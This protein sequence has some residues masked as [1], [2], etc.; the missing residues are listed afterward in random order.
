MLADQLYDIFGEMDTALR[1]KLCDPVHGAE[2]QRI[3][4]QLVERG[5]QWNAIGLDLT[6]LKDASPAELTLLH[7][8]LV[9]IIAAA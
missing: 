9:T 4:V 3:L 2:V 8:L 6:N 7:E 5:L 1:T